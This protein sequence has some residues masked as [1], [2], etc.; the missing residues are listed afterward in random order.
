MSTINEKT[1]L[2]RSPPLSTH[3]DGQLDEKIS[4]TEEEEKAVVRKR[5]SLS[6]LSCPPVLTVLCA[7]SLPLLSSSLPRPF[8]T[9]FPLL[10]LS[11]LD[12]RSRPHLP[13]PPVLFR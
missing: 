13:L 7:V 1:D 11:R 5:A 10:S 6:P 4:F 8:L 9:L 2:E 12:T 3:S